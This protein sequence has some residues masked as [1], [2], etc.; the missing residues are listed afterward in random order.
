[1]L[2]P[3]LYYTLLNTRQQ[4][5]A[6]QAA[7]DRLAASQ[8]TQRRALGGLLKAAGTVLLALGMRL[9]GEPAPASPHPADAAL[10]SDQRLSKA[11]GHS[12]DWPIVSQED[13]SASATSTGVAL[14]RRPAPSEACS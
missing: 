1:M 12:A 10:L 4:E 13:G 6:D 3:R 14:K 11:N 9:R 5:L 2:D 7:R 8:R